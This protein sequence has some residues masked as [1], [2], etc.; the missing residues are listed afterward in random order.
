MGFTDGIY[1][2][3]LQMGFTDGIYRW[4]LQLGFTDGIYRWDLQM[5]FTD[6]VYRW[7]LQM[8][9]NSVAKGLIPVFTW[10]CHL[11]LSSARHISPPPPILFLLKSISLLSSSLC[12]SLPT[13]SFTFRFPHQNPTCISLLLRTR[14]LWHP[15]HTLW[16]HHYN[17]SWQ[18]VWFSST[19]QIPFYLI[20]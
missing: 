5:G 4:D 9:F 15:S 11:S 12:L 8:G 16:F 10:S 13:G 17:S 20:T 14:H 6:G 1:S 7:G 3:D 2:W 19:C 18:A